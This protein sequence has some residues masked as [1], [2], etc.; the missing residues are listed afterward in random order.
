MR[1]II[2]QYVYT[3]VLWAFIY[4]FDIRFMS[5]FLENGNALVQPVFYFYLCS[6]CLRREGK[7]VETVAVLVAL[8]IGFHQVAQPHQI[9]F[10][11][12]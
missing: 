9:F 4:S 8:C 12:R 2:F 1:S 11:L 7:I 3:F 10:L 6:F 5:E